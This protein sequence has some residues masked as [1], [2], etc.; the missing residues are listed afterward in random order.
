MEKL[1]FKLLARGSFGLF[2][3]ICALAGAP[4][5]FGQNGTDP[6][7][8]N[9]TFESN[10]GTD[11]KSIDVEKR[12]K[13]DRFEDPT[14]DND[15]FVGWF[16]D[17]KLTQKWDFD[18]DVVNNDIILYAKW[19]VVHKVEFLSDDTVKIENCEDGKL[20]V[21][22]SASKDDYDF[23]GWYDTAG[24]A[25][26]KWDFKKP[27]YSDKTFYARWTPRPEK[28]LQAIS[29]LKADFQ[30][31]K[32][33]IDVANAK[34]G[35]YFFWLIISCSAIAFLILLFGILLLLFTA[36][37][38]GL[39]KELTKIV[40]KD[41]L[42]TVCEE[43]GFI[44]SLT[45]KINDRGLPAQM[46]NVAPTRD[47]S[48]YVIDKIKKDNALLEEENRR[49][50]GQINELQEERRTS[51]NIASGVL[52]PK[53]VFNGWA[54]NPVNPLPRAFYYTNLPKQLQIRTVQNFSSTSDE[55]ALWITNYE[56]SQKYLFPNPR[57][58][59]QMTDISTFYK[60]GTGF[61]KG[62]GQNRFRII[63]ACEMN[64][65]GFIEFPGEMV[66]L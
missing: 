29:E 47:T 31:T 23:V 53:D 11:Q 45:L 9:I 42:K 61:M 22:Y 48:T 8:C 17:E 58:I 38:R 10:G 62:K 54:A 63:K 28:I 19:Q 15:E 32:E 27:I 66:Q 33:Y 26:D 21:E 34:A 64:P 55:Q 37:N 2:V 59:D 30:Q 65:N 13:I 40:S 60:G 14:K 36:K 46:A 41:D 16:K 24:F 35:K 49:L 43:I 39:K 4:A 1:S 20:V 12:G 50:K 7:Y 6:Q 5:L 18:K 25:G 44:K 51:D 52:D 3:L 56:G 57:V